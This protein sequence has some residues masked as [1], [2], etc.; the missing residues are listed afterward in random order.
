[1][2]E[3]ML[4][5]L[6]LKDPSHL[7]KLHDQPGGDTLGLQPLVYHDSKIGPEGADPLTCLVAL[8]DDLVMLLVGRATLRAESLHSLA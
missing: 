4:I 7:G 8:S 6:R 2:Q 3:I 5:A 1:M